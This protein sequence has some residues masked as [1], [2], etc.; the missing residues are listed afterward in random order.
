MNPLVEAAEIRDV[1]EIEMPKSAPPKAR[2]LSELVRPKHDQDPDELFQHRFLC[3]GGGL[4]LCGPTG[5][6][7]S[8]LAMQCT[9]L[10]A[11]R[12]NCQALPM[13]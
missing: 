5:I 13:K 9:I 7:K 2:L 6:G 4:L 8:S 3:R 11:L 1:P 12:H 10:W